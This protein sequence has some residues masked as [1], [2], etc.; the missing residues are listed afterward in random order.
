MSSKKIQFCS[1]FSNAHKVRIIVH[2]IFYYKKLCLFLE[3][4]T[5][6]KTPKLESSGATLTFASYTVLQ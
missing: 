1:L 2:D 6:R 5:K 3:R 4:H